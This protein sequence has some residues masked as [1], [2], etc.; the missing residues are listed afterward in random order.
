MEELRLNEIAEVL[1]SE[2][3]CPVPVQMNGMLKEEKPG[4][5]LVILR[6]QEPGLGEIVGRIDESSAAVHK[7]HMKIV[8]AEETVAAPKSEAKQRHKKTRA[9]KPTELSYD[10]PAILEGRTLHQSLVREPREDENVLKSGQH[11]RKYGSVVEV[12]KW[13]GMQIFGLTLEER[14]TCP[15]YCQQYRVC[16]GNRMSQPRA[17]RYAHGPKLL[18]N[19]TKELQVLSSDPATANGYVVR[20]HTLGDFYDLE[21]VSFW[22]EQLQAHPKL[23]IWG[24]TERHVDD[25]FREAFF[26]MKKDHPERFRMRWSNN[27]GEADSAMVV[28]TIEEAEAVDGAMVCPMH[29]GKK[30]NCATCG[31]CWESA[32]PIVFVK[33]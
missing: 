20:L 24:F 17:F 1:F 6:I 3:N 18:A 16:Y 12:G 11:S 29:T 8:K 25:D 33:H 32:V 4:Y 30:S 14:K 13:R 10:D 31:L 26:Q 28:D 15:D 23:H 7:R 5:H 19:L 27:P 22:A 2:K 9:V 21:Y